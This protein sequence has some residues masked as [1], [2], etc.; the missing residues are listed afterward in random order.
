MRVNVLFSDRK[1]PLS[2][3]VTG[4]K[5]NTFNAITTHES[6]GSRRSPYANVVTR[7][8]DYTFPRLAVIDAPCFVINDHRDNTIRLLF[9]KFFIYTPTTVKKPLTN[10][11]PY[12]NGLKNV[13]PPPKTV[14]PRGPEPPLFSRPKHV[15]PT[16][17]VGHSPSP[18]R[19]AVLVQEPCPPLPTTVSVLRARTRA[20]DT[21]GRR[22]KTLSN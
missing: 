18:P 6:D 4:Q 16:P 8:T 21:S 13:P 10:T 15:S 1:R 5:I 20:R 19:T 14:P 11:I 7:Q 22:F 2:G 3:T 12:R 17:Q 9:L